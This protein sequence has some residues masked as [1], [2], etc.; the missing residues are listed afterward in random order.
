MIGCKSQ[1][2]KGPFPCMGSIQSKALL[3]NGS[4]LGKDMGREKGMKCFIVK[5]TFF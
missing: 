3:W 5:L 4:H 2:S 1:V